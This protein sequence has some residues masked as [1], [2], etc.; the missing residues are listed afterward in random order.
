M[1]LLVRRWFGQFQNSGMGLAETAFPGTRKLK[2]LNIIPY[3]AVAIFVPLLWFA[4]DREP[5][6][7]RLSGEIIPANPKQ[8]EWVKVRWTLRVSKVCRPS[9]PLNITRKI[10][11]R[12]NGKIT[13]LAPVQG[14]FGA[15]GGISITR[16]TL[17]RP[18]QIPE[19]TE[20]GDSTYQ[21]TACFAC[22]PVQALWPICISTPNVD[23]TV[24]KR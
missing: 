18:F 15:E 11:N 6:Y 1:V 23:F 5:P 3:V 17:T 22:N 10:I 24:E 8:L 4:M 12:Q 2:Y 14:V 19:T 20:P 13:E 16:E 21:S 7:V 9:N